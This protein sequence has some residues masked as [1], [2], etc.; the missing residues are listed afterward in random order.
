MIR[1]VEEL[2]P[3]KPTPLRNL[4]REAVEA[5]LELQPG[6]T[7]E[8]SESHWA[9]DDPVAMSQCAR[10]VA[11]TKGKFNVSIVCQDEAIYV[12]RWEESQNA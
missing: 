8:I 12:K 4:D 2:P 10:R 9:F 5:I 6:D 7:I 11:K 3:Q 1:P